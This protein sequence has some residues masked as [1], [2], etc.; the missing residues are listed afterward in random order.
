MIKKIFLTLLALIV[1][2]VLGIIVF[3]L[4]FDL[5]HY[6]HFVET[7]A[8]DTLGFPVKIKSMS[9]KLS[10]VPTINVEGVKILDENQEKT[11]L[12]VQKL[13]A[14]VELTGL[15]RGQLIVPQIIIR[16][17]N[18]V[19]ANE[20]IKKTKRSSSQS[21]PQKST[22]TSNKIWIDEISIDTLN[23]KIGKDDP[24]EF[25]INKFTLKELSKFSF[26]FIY[27]KK[28]MSVSGNFGSVL[29]LA[30][31]KENLPINLTLKQDKANL[32]INGKIGDVEN[33]KKISF[34][35]DGKIPNLSNFLKNWAIKNDK[36]PTL[37]LTFKTSLEGDLGKMELRNTN[38]TLG[39]SDLIFNT[40]GT[41]TNLKQD[42]KADL[43]TSLS[44]TTGSLTQLWGIKPVELTTKV[45]VDKKS[46][47]A[48]E[49]QLNVGRSDITGQLTMYTDQKPFLLQGKINSSYCDIYD[50]IES[51]KTTAVSSSKTEQRKDILSTKKLP[52]DLLKKI[53]LDIQLNIAN[54]KFSNEI[55]EYAN[56]NTTI[57]VKN[58]ELNMPTQI[59]IFGGKIQ[60]QL[61]IQAENQSVI[62]A[63]TANDIQL[64]KIKTLNKN[65]QNS[66]FNLSLSV[67]SMGESL[68][69]L[70]ASANGQLTAELTSGQIINKWFNTLPTT[71]NILRGNANSLAFSTDQKTEL[72]CGALNMPIK[73]GILTSQNQIAL[74]TN[75][76]NFVVNGN[77]NLKNETVDLSM[78]PSVNQTRGMANELL[79]TTQA[80]KLTGPWAKITT[81]TEPMQVVET[82]AKIFGKKLSGEKQ[83]NI[84]I[85][86]TTL[87]QKVLGRSVSKIQKTSSQ[88]T[89]A[90]KQ[91]KPQVTRQTQPDLK[92]QLIQSLS[93]A[94]T[95]QVAHTKKQ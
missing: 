13:E 21:T 7:K 27:L 91:A 53:N 79:G 46:V 20:T 68:K 30:T 44:L 74:E 1:I 4:T 83:E 94:L 58:A 90:Q 17:A 66:S 31:K 11:I 33:L 5:N 10:F 54:L 6:R 16:N 73:D 26:D 69:A 25:S 57:G 42:P 51:K 65:I 95:D 23:C 82:L 78:I 45:G 47:T 63:I 80:I 50:I 75:T 86:P 59:R 55:S 70:A 72:I 48:S 8:S 32:K 88:K 34:Q 49:I 2:V 77:V 89:T 24:Y 61:N 19:W 18:F 38:F 67:K 29:E 3:L 92:Q 71:L 22:S 37:P 14:V 52:F 84:K 15:L 81:Q 35:L 85:E 40:K 56:I 39:K 93:Q 76:L 64:N 43:N 87:C 12:D 28:T 60:N 36:I 41:L 9:T 62:I